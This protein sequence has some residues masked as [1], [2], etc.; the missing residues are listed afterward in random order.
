MSPE[1]T[2]VGAL[3]VYLLGIGM[4]YYYGEQSGR[5]KTRDE[6]MAIVDRNSRRHDAT[7]RKLDGLLAHKERRADRQTAISEL[8][9][10]WD[11][12]DPSEKS[13]MAQVLRHLRD[14][15]KECYRLRAIIEVRLSPESLDHDGPA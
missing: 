6:W 4:G 12:D 7:L 8:L 13:K 15:V 10:T 9:E 1:Q 14:T 2:A 3:I 11:I 5:M